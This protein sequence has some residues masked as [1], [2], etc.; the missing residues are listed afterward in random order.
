MLHDIARWPP[1]GAP[2]ASAQDIRNNT[3][4]ERCQPARAWAG[5][6]QTRENGS[7]ASVRHGHAVSK[8]VAKEDASASLRC[9]CPPRPRCRRWPQM[10]GIVMMGAS[11]PS[12]SSQPQ[13]AH[14]AHGGDRAHVERIVEPQRVRSRMSARAGPPVVHRHHVGARQDR[15][16][17]RRAPARPQAWRRRG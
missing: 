4:F 14:A 17:A 6:E 12:W 2:Q 16:Q 1:G 10:R 8:V 11:A 9:G 13:F 3:G 5:Q 15:L 7:A